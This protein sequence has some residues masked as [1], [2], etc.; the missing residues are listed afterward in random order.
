MIAYIEDIAPR[1]SEVLELL[2]LNELESANISI[3]KISDKKYEINGEYSTRNINTFIPADD[4][5]T[6]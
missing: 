5:T 4:W 1:L 2:D 3:K 6:Q